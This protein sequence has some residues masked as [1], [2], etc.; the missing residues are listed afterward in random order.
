MT[1]SLSIKQQPMPMCMQMSNA[2]NKSHVH[3][4]HAVVILRVFSCPFFT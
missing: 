1:P 3:I 4:V 2:M